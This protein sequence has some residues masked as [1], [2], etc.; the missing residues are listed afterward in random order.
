M[1]NC[2]KQK[3]PINFSFSSTFMCC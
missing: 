1:L 3:Q 2:V